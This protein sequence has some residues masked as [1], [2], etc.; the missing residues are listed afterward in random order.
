[1]LI[2]RFS[3]LVVGLFFFAGCTEKPNTLSSEEKAEGF[4][5]LFDGESLNGW[6]AYMEDPIEGAWS[7]QDG[8]MVLRRVLQKRNTPIS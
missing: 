6:R 5:W 7:V 4:K 2:V 1:M 3:I 8:M